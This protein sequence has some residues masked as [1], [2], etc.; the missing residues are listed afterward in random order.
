MTSK[1]LIEFTFAPVDSKHLTEFTPASAGC[2]SKDIR[3]IEKRCGYF[4]IFSKFALN[5]WYEEGLTANIIPEEYFDVD[6][7]L[8]GFDYKK[9][10]FQNRY[11]IANI[12]DI[13]QTDFGYSFESDVYKW[14]LSKDKYICLSIPGPFQHISY[15]FGYHEVLENL[16]LDKTG[17]K[18]L[19]SES[20]DYT[21]D[22][23]RLIKTRG[24]EFYGVW[25]WEDIAYDNG[26]FFS[27]IEYEDLLSE[28]HQKLIE[29]I[30][31][32]NK[33]VFFHSDG[34]I[35]SVLS[36][37]IKYGIDAI[38]PLESRFYR[39][40]EIREKFPNI[41][42][43]GNINYAEVV[44]NKFALKKYTFKD[45]YIYSSDSAILEDI[46][47]FDYIKFINFITD[48]TWV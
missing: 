1:Q 3:K 2:L 29:E 12:Q 4:D 28:F 26:L 47:L 31:V 43:L 23:I 13:E 41:V 30:K 9:T 19:F 17:I 10:F 34:D 18:K 24:F 33:K 27:L 25:I 35:N 21:L 15:L 16:L 5:R 8:F 39:F 42:C 44:K 14:A 22:M 40:N 32:K 45:K 11:N 7:L 48:R 20:V 37:L 38:H 46:S 6:I 36:E